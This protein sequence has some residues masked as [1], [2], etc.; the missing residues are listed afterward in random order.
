MSSTFCLVKTRLARHTCTYDLNRLCR[1]TGIAFHAVGDDNPSIEGMKARYGLNCDGDNPKQY[2]KDGLLMVNLIRCIGE[3]DESLSKNSCRDAWI[4]YTLKIIHHFSS[5]NKPVIVLTAASSVLPEIYIPAVCSGDL[6]QVPHP[7]APSEGT[8]DH[9]QNIIKVH[10]WL[11]GYNSQRHRNS[12]FS[13]FP[14]PD[15]FDH[16]Y[17]RGNCCLPLTEPRLPP[18][19]RIPPSNYWDVP[20]PPPPLDYDYDYQSWTPY[21]SRNWRYNQ[22]QRLFSNRYGVPLHRRGRFPSSGSYSPYSM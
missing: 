8:L 18:H 21:A 17:N 15:H 2:I 16:T 12:Y 13:Q 5:K 1:A 20:P 6:V 3:H 9:Q 10:E 4:A 11:N 22:P 19:I 7:S 14:P